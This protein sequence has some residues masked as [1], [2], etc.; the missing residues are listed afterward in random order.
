MEIEAALN[1]AVEDMLAG[2]QGPDATLLDMKQQVQQ[3]MD[4]YR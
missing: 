1:R 2:K 4:Q 3:V